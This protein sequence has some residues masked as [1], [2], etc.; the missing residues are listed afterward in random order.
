MTYNVECDVKSLLAYLLTCLFVVADIVAGGST[1]DTPGVVLVNFVDVI[2][3]TSLSSA[4]VY[5]VSQVT[6][7]VMCHQLVCCTAL[8]CV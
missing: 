5:L 3:F 1:A 6:G 2:V 4:L 7:P 8:L